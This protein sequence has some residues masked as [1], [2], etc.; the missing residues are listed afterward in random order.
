MSE[1]LIERTFVAVD[2][3]TGRVCAL[4]VGGVT[5]RPEVS[6]DGEVVT[7]DEAE[8]LA[9]ARSPLFEMVDAREV[10]QTE[11]DGAPESEDESAPAGSVRSTTEGNTDPEEENRN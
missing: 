8:A 3:V 7:T 1:T 2:D 9:L 11:T 6:A 4:T 5:Y 10:S